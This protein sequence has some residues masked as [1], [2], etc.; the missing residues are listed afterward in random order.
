MMPRALKF[1]TL[2]G[3]FFGLAGAGAY[4]GLTLVIRSQDTVVIPELVGRHVVYALEV[5][6]DLGLNT[7]VKGSEFSPEA[8]KHSV[9]FQNPAA[10]AE[11]KKGRDVRL[12]ISKGP[13][14]LVMPNLTGLSSQQARLILEENG[15]C[16]GH[17]SLVFDPR[18]FAD[19]VL[20]QVPAPGSTVRH[21]RC[22]DLLVS[23]GPRPAAYAM[24]DLTGLGLDDAVLLCERTHLR[25]GRVSVR[26]DP[27]QPLNVVIDQDP[28]KGSRVTAGAGVALVLN[29]RKPPLGPADAAEAA[30]GRLFRFRLPEGFLKQRVRV[31]CNLYGI[32]T[33]LVNDYFRP[34]EEIWLLV[35]AEAY[36]SLVVYLDEKPVKARPL[37]D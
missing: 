16:L 1:L 19:G 20:A 18:M 2:A 29:R 17:L 8:P 33:D 15:L 34:G 9:L 24:P 12:I 27:D 23:A 3:L 37:T 32:G 26:Y 22:A 5:L 36:P 30:E 6:S 4:L 13:E 25:A 35:P 31:H 21:D 28:A 7:R 11:I 10:G 14:T